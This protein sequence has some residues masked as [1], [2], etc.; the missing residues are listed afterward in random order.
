MP[1]QRSLWGGKPTWPI[2]LH[3][4]PNDPKPASLVLPDPQIEPLPCS[5]QIHGSGMRRREFLSA[6]GG[7]A[8]WPLTAR[9]QHTGM[10]L[11]GVLGVESANPFVAFFPKGLAEAGFIEGRNL[12]LEYRWAESQIDRLPALAADL[13]RLQP[14]VIA[15]LSGTASALAVKNATNTI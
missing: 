15:T 5:V 9:A 8:A 4:S 7:A 2:A 6:L 13:V 12:A 1:A 14:V 10:P 3:T 11:V